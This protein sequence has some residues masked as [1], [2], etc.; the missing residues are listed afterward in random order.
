MLKKEK[1]SHLPLVHQLQ[2]QPQVLQP[3]VLLLQQVLVQLAPVQV[4]LQPQVQP[5]Q[6]QLPLLVHLLQLPRVVLVQPAPVPQLLKLLLQPQLPGPLP[7]PVQPPV[8]Q[9]QRLL[10]L[11][12]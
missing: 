6:R 4:R 3:V 1:I 5:H 8:L 9:L 12:V 7:V 11:K 10:Q 2:L